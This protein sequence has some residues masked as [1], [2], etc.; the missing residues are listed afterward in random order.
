[1]HWIGEHLNWKGKIVQVQ[2]GHLPD[3]LGITLHT[4]Q[5][6]I[7]GSNRIREELSYREAFSFEEVQILALFEWGKILCCEAYPVEL[8]PSVLPDRFVVLNECEVHSY[9]HNKEAIPL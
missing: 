4:E 8:V 9:L 6:I 3:E 7:V 2:S 5:K 1:M